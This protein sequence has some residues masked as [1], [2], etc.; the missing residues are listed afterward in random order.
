MKVNT[1]FIFNSEIKEGYDPDKYSPSLQKYHI[2]LWSKELPNGKVFYLKDYFPKI[3]RRLIHSSE[4]GNFILSSDSIGHSYKSVK[5]IKGII[6][7]IN[8][9]KIES[10]YSLCCTIGAYI[11]FPA[12]KIDKKLTINVHRGL[13]PLIK[14]RWDLTLEC[15]RR[16]YNNIE[17]PLN[18]TLSRYAKFFNLFE[19]FQGYV[20]HFLLQDMVSKDYNKINFFIPFSEFDRCPLPKNVDE[21]LLYREKLMFFIKSRNERINSSK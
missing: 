19:N 18:E 20:E 8:N 9:E 5:R 1:N 17:N 7:K 3:P 15:I 2:K 6:D 4:M 14:D 16:F 21:Y 13:H 12:Q 10:F 11:I